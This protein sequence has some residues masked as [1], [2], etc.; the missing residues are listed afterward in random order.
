VR[1]PVGLFLAWPWLG[2]LLWAVLHSL[3]FYL[4]LWG[5]RLYRT[6]GKDHIEFEGSYE[7]NPVWEKTVD[8]GLVFPPR[9]AVSIVVVG[10][11]FWGF[12]WLAGRAGS[13]GAW[14]LALLLGALVFTRVGVIALHA[15]NIWLYR[16]IARGGAMEGHVRYSRKTALGISAVR[17]TGLAALLAAAALVAPS[18]WLWGGAGGLVLLGAKTSILYLR[19]K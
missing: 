17:W 18:P 8:R 4:T 14:S 12:A 1:D 6:A 2:A 10:A 5:A 9:F 7:L 13:F 11:L 3:D 16:H 19:R 15:Q